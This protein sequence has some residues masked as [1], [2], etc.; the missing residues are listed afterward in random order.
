MKKVVLAYSGG[1]DT[2]VCIPLLKEKYGYDQVIT[3]TV[4]VGQPAEEIKTASEKAKK[5]A[6]KHYTIDAKDEFVR[7]YIFP[8]IKANA[9]YEGYVIGTSMARPLIARK[10]VDVAKKE[11]PM[12]WLTDA[13]V[14]VTTSCGSRRYSARRICRSSRLCAR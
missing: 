12:P 8:M 4:D 5:I 2:S 13:R 11:R 9:L 1:L 14:R 7:D 3:V 10:C 6:D